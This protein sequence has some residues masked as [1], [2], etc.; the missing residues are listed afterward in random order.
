MNDTEGENSMK[1]IFQIQKLKIG[2]YWMYN[3]IL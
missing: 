2:V 3:V 1:N